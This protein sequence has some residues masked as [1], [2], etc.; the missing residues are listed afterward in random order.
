MSQYVS[1]SQARPLFRSS[2]AIAGLTALAAWLAAAGADDKPADA[3]P[4]SATEKPLADLHGD[5]LP[6]GAIARLGSIRFRSSA[7]SVAYS[8]DGKV[9]A[10][11]GAD[12]HIRLIDPAT[13]KEIRR[14][15]GHQPRTYNPPRDNKTAF[16]ALVGSVGEGNVTTVAFSSDGKQLASGGWDETIRL[17]DV[18]KGEEIRRLAGHQKGMIATVAFSKDGKHLASRGGN[19]GTVRIWD[20]ATGKELFQLA[21][22]G[23]VNPWRFNRDSALAFT[24]DGHTLAVGD[25][26][27]IRFLEVPSG[28]EIKTWDAHLSCV[29]LC[30]SPDGDLLATGGI[31][32]GHD[33]Y[34]LRIWDVK[35][36]KEL[37][38][39][40]LPKM[41]PPISLA[42]SANNEQ[43]AA[44]VEEDILTIFAVATGKPLHRLN[45]YWASRV[46]YAP[47]GKTIVS[48]RGPVIRMWDP[49]TGKEKFL[50]YEGHQSGVASVAV[51]PD[52]KR[53]A[54]AGDSIR[55][56]DPSGKPIREIPVQGGVSVVAFSP[57]GERLAAACRDRA[58]RIFDVES[59]KQ[60]DQLK[61]HQHMLCGLAISPDGKKLASGD[62][63][64]TIKIWDL[65]TSKQ[66]NEIENLSGTE[67]LS[68][69]FSPDSALL[70]CGG[71][72]NDS[73]F[74]PKGTINIQGVKMERKEGYLV[75]M[76]DAE[77]A[78]E[79]R[80]FSGLSDKI[81]SVAFSKDGK[82][83]AA[84][85]KDGRIA[86]W[87][88]AS[89]KD[90]LYILAHPTPEDKGAGLALGGDFAAS[91]A[92]AFSPDRKTLASVSP[93]K[94]IRLWD[95]NTARELR[96]IQAPDGGFHCLAFGKEG[97]TLITGS[98]DTTVMVWDLVNLPKEQKPKE[99]SSITIGD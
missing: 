27:V 5:S 91:P 12:N 8:A 40:E 24:P 25:A 83:L 1:P 63:Q 6:P 38:R 82:M 85:S 26:K 21:S 95:I 50:E 93:D 43:L 29:S 33:Q 92:I 39:C 99:P 88:S 98:S 60:V 15:A 17:W 77:T 11:G 14:L 2:L 96:R 57:D 72:W 56:W 48:V 81:K 35:T 42:F 71:A 78:K 36:E 55:L 9:L 16:D 13:G 62:V 22:V 23:R 41:E 3:K 70:A 67:C 69:A 32:P 10:V 54:S 61:G 66:L 59:G 37:R 94:T 7:T 80:R 76:W 47:D 73:S 49:A 19:D 79:V 74:L 4:D 84:A 75:L 89:G 87:D 53:I 68:L 86:L 28:K 97:K 65:A 46:T 90:H 44:V 20:T 18:E 58:V 51:S 30:Y 45:Q 31:E 34:S 64:S 52:G